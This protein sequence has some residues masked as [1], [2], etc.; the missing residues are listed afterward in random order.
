MSGIEKPIR[1]PSTTE[2]RVCCMNSSSRLPPPSAPP[3]PAPPSCS[4]LTTSCVSAKSSTTTTSIST[5][6]V[7]TVVVKGPLACSS[8][9]IAMAEEGERATARQAMSSAADILSLSVTSTRKG[10][11]YSQLEV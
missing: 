4:E 7:R 9:M 11:N 10:R 6:T 2:R 3:S 5:V 8:S 1:Q